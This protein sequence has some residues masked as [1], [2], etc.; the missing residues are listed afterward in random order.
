MTAQR[1][2]T[3]GVSAGVSISIPN[4]KQKGARFGLRIGVLL[5]GLV[6]MYYSLYEL[7][8]NGVL[9]DMVFNLALLTLMG[10]AIAKVY[11]PGTD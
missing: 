7:Q 9:V 2:P 3:P 6:T 4:R 8:L 10:I 1:R 5:V 11:G